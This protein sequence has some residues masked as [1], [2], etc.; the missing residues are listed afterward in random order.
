MAKR[1]AN[2]TSKK[3]GAK[4]ET[5]ALKPPRHSLCANST[6]TLAI[7]HLAG[8]ARQGVDHASLC[9]IETGMPA[10]QASH[11]TRV[12]LGRRRRATGTSELASSRAIIADPLMFIRRNRP[13][14]PGCPSCASAFLQYYCGNSLWEHPTLIEDQRRS[15]R[16][17]C[18]MPSTS[19]PKCGLVGGLVGAFC[20]DGVLGERPRLFLAG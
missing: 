11:P 4:S 7:A 8:R 5:T 2:A 20:D 12:V 6:M 10:A 3:R 18:T 15:G 13:H 17:T 14:R 19:L 16:R 1:F 9:T